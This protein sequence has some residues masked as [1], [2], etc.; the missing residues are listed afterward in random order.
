MCVGGGGGGGGGALSAISGFII[1]LKHNDTLKV[2]RLFIFE[3]NILVYI[4][5]NIKDYKHMKC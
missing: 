3:I 4:R 1:F 5:R 2:K